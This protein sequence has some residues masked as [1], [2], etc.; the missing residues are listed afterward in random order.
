MDGALPVCR[1]RY[2]AGACLGESR[3]REKLRKAPSSGKLRIRGGFGVSVF[4]GFPLR[5]VRR[6]CWEPTNNFNQ[7]C[8]TS[9]RRRVSGASVFR[10]SFAVS[11]F[12]DQRTPNRRCGRRRERKPAPT[13]PPFVLSCFSCAQFRSQQPG[14]PLRWQRLVPV[15]STRV[16]PRAGRRRACR[17]R[18]AF[19][20]RARR[21]QSRA[22]APG[23]RGSGWR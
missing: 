12:R 3:K 13:P 18:G 9:G 16:P 19:G 1:A 5:S 4:V 2:E 21:L 11:R 8:R 20:C 10:C 6:A 7:V 17:R 15:R 23:R 14:S 22:G